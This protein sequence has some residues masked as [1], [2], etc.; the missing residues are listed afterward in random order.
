[1]QAVLVNNDVLKETRITFLSQND[2]CVLLS[3]K[4]N[5]DDF[6]N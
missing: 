4:M 1:M 5:Y 3:N 2:V 6:Q